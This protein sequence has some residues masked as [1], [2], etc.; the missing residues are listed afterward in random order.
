ALRHWG[1]DAPA[2][3]RASQPSA[4]RRWLFVNSMG[5]TLL[6]INPGA[7][8]RKDRNPEAKSQRVELTRAFFLSD[9]EISVG[10]FQRF[11]SDANT[12]TDEK[13]A[14]WPGADAQ[15]S[16]SPDHPVQMV[17]W[18]DAVLFCNWLSRKEGRSPCY[19]R[20][21]TKEKRQANVEQDTRRLDSQATGY[22]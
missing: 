4:A 12:P 20:I 15:V 5:M 22:R 9:R 2:R 7:F 10:Q 21:V 3:S 11:I 18:R 17:N 16:P 1:L 14:E 13:P 8:V 6:R 19:A